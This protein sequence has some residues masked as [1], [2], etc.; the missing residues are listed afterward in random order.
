MIWIVHDFW[1][2]FTINNEQLEPNI[3]NVFVNK[4]DKIQ[5]WHR[6]SLIISEN[7][8]IVQSHFEKCL[9]IMGQ[10]KKGIYF[11]YS[12]SLTLKV[13]KATFE[14]SHVSKYSV[15]KANSDNQW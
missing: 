6:E 11:W 3:N 13:I 14:F 12:V 5:C 1:L 8:W 15:S 9:F 7:F 10:F 2:S 4:Y